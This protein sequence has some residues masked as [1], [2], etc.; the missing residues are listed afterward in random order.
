ML[1][2]YV[3]IKLM[4]FLFFSLRQASWFLFTVRRAFFGSPSLELWLQLDWLVH[5][6]KKELVG[7]EGYATHVYILE[8]T[9]H[10]PACVNSYIHTPEN[11]T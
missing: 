10:A 7:W 2:N 9:S 8:H 11:L 4:F 3:H 5:D 1:L 6:P